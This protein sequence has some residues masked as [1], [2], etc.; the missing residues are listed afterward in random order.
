MRAKRR[1]SVN[2]GSTVLVPGS[3]FYNQR[4]Y[5]DLCITAVNQHW[6]DSEEK[7][8]HLQDSSRSKPP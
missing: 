8:G 1:L 7:R 6:I 2:V 3:H 5:L 4:R